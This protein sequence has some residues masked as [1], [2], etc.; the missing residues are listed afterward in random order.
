MDV[1]VD[2]ERQWNK[3]WKATF[4]YSMQK[5]NPM[6]GFSEL[7]YTSHILVADVTHKIDRR[8][9]VRAELQY[10]YSNDYEGDWM[11]ALV[12]YNLSPSWSFFVSDMY[13]HQRIETFNDKV[14]YYSVGASYTHGRSRFQLS[15]GRNRAGMICSGGV[16]R[17]TPSYTGFNLLISSSF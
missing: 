3:D 9:S 15:Y 16:C 5:R 1:N 4:M 6:K 14:N 17:Y 13:N 8:N 11:A 2:V 10:L 7:I 12:E